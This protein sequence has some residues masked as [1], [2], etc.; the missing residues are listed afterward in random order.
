MGGGLVSSAEST[1]TINERIG[2]ANKDAA[3]VNMRRAHIGCLWLLLIHWMA[4]PR[5]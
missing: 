4:P 3:A 1:N 5:S 2:E